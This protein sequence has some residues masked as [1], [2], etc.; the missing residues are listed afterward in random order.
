MWKPKIKKVSIVLFM[1]EIIGHQIKNVLSSES[2]FASTYCTIRT[3]LESIIEL[4]FV[5]DEELYDSI[6]L[7]RLEVDDF[8]FIYLPPRNSINCRLDSAQFIS[9]NLYLSNTETLTLGN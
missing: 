9:T 1:V 8:L 7:Y 5:F 4:R 3:R 6:S 2:F